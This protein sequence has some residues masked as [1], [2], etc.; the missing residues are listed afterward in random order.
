MAR[1]RWIVALSA[2]TLLVGACSSQAADEGGGSG[3]SD[4]ASGDSGTPI[5]GITEDA[6]NIS[7][8]GA[9][10]AALA[11]AG[12]APD[13]GDMEATLPALEEWVDEEG[14]IAGRDIQLTVDLVDGTGGPDVVR[15]A[16]IK[17]TEED[18]AAIV[19]V[20]PA[21]SRELVRCTAVQQGTITL[22]MPGWDDPL[23][24]EAQGRLF[25]IGSHTS[26]STFRNAE[27]WADVLDAQGLL[28]GRTIGVLTDESF[29][30]HRVGTEEGLVPHLESLGYAPAEVAVLPCPVGDS[31]CEQHEPAA[32][33]FADAGVDLV[34][35]NAGPLSGPAVLAAAQGI[36]WAPEWVVCCN[37]VTNTVAQFYA[38]VAAEL[39]GTVGVSTL[40]PEPSAEADECNVEVAARAGEEYERG[41]DAY[42][43]TAVNCIALLALR[44]AVAGI[45]GDLTEE[46]VIEAIE[47]LGE[48]PSNTG[49]PGSIG[50]DKHDAGDLL[51]VATYDDGD[52]VFTIDE[53]IEPFEVAP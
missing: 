22:G 26:M 7:F 51:L 14:G 28:E 34:F 10:F 29:E 31:D 42:G 36:G 46:G 11:E 53:S 44:D 32:Q 41:S 33:S 27:G 9:D 47:A 40:F 21:V 39:D 25:S 52:G 19:L 35:L 37:T 8:I 6:I 13:L 2:L 20:S 48:V 23:Y 50:P 43:F 12:L 1:H 18:D 30:A 49:P 15:A 5:A 3:A 45:E 38:D 24:Q 17:A 16:C 4:D